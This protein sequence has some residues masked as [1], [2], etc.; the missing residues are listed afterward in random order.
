MAEDVISLGEAARISG[1]SP[2]T[3]KRWAAAG[4]IPV[5]RG[6]WTTAAAAQA[7]VV[8][9]MRE[10]GH[11][12]DELRTAVRD[13]RLAFGYVEDLIPGARERTISRAE[14]AARTGLEEE[15]IERVMTLLGTPTALEGTL[16]EQD[17]DAID[18]MSAVLGAGF[19]LVALLQLVRVY[20]QSIRKIAEAEVRLFHLYVHEP[21]IRQGVDALEMAEEMEGLAR[22]LLPLTSPLMEYIHQRYLRFYIEQDVVGHMEVDYGGMRQM[23]RVR[24]AFCFVDLTGFVRY[25]E[26]EGDEE[27]LDLIERFIETVEATLPAEALIV[28]TIGDEVMIVSPD[29]VTLT[30]W[31]VGFLT[32]FKERPQPRVGV[33][34]GRAVYRDGDYFGTDVN[35]THRVV[36][37]ALGGEVMVTTAV[38]DAIGSSA[39]LEFDPIGRVELKGFPEPIELFVARARE[40]GN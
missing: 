14:A 27:A 2:S 19:P 3:L 5:R 25:T 21:L 13:G 16:N 7:R 30:E 20:A 8:A 12:L 24:M 28:K 23:G 35:L 4:V 22:D 38:A 33:H 36:A 11:S 15:L 39:Y 6:R 31:S 32:L 37:R 34:Y 40:P 9:R 29:P 18:S 26:E 10:R 1:V 17:V